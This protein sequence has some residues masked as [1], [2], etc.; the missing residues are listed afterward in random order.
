MQLNKHMGRATKWLATL[1][2][3]IFV[4]A[5]QAQAHLLN[6]TRITLNQVDAQHAELDISVDLTRETGSSESYYQL[7]RIQAPLSDPNI[8][9]LAQKLISAT[10]ITLDEQLLN[11]Q[12]AQVDLPSDISKS[13]FM[14]D[15]NWPMTR[16][17]FTATLPTT[18][19]DSPAE[20]S[21]KFTGN[22]SFE[23][24]IAISIKQTSSGRSLNRWLV[25]DQQSPSFALQPDKLQ[26]KARDLHSDTTSEWLHYMWQGIIHIIPQGWDHALFV[27]GLFLGIT[28]VRYLLIWVTGFTIAHTLTLGLA[29][30]GAIAIPASIIEPITA[31]SIL[32]VAVEN[33]FWRPSAW[34]RLAIVIT[35]GLIHGLGFASA[36]SQLGLPS[37]GL[38]LALISFNI[39][40]E[41]AQ[42]GIILVAFLLLANWRNHPK[43]QSMIVTPG[44]TAI[45]LVA[46]IILCQRLWG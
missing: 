11:W 7:S 45:A 5:P 14:S 16:F 21:A 30:F 33:I 20:L 36:L 23:E 10:N 24:P 44:S 22:F 9:A 8:N 13:E 18:G 42:L 29:A 39:G 4:F 12:L 32:W 46:G 3:V 41:L 43:W 34:W 6:M 27:L 28:R 26:P 35:F 2:L 25:R 40:V 19:E 1:Y 17:L 38:V 15:L 31:L 37:Q